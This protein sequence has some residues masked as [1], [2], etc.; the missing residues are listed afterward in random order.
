MSSYPGD[1]GTTPSLNPVAGDVQ[2]EPCSVEK[3]GSSACVHKRIL[4][5]PF[6]LTNPLLLLA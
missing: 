6:I 4:G 1:L 3:R 2:S 5:E